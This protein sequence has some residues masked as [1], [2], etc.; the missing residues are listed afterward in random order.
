[1]SRDQEVKPSHAKTGALLIF[2]IVSRPSELSLKRM[3]TV[4]KES[5]M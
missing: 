1:M 2:R 5:E 4:I 3:L